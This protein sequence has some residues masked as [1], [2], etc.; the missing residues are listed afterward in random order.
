MTLFDKNLRRW[1][2]PNEYCTMMKVSIFINV[3][4]KFKQR[5]SI[6]PVKICAWAYKV[7]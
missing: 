1:A 6:D 5:S 4:S 3:L 7:M 2:P